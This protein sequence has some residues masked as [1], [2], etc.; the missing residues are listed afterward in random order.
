VIGSTPT[1]RLRMGCA[2]MGR[3]CC[4][5]GWQLGRRGCGATGGVLIHV[6]STPRWSTRLDRMNVGDASC[7]GQGQLTRGDTQPVSARVIPGTPTTCAALKHRCGPRAAPSAQPAVGATTRSSPRSRTLCRNLAKSPRGSAP[8][9][10][11]V[12]G[13]LTSK[14]VATSTFGSNLNQINHFLPP[15]PAKSRRMKTLDFGGC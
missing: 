6:P 11:H 2:W 10:K 14:I 8:W 9:R 3:T 12:S 15:G 5:A 4:A 1:E 7:T 13:L